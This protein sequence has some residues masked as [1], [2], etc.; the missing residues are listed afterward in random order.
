MSNSNSSNGS[1]GVGAKAASPKGLKLEL[2]LMQAGVDK[3]LTKAGMNVMGQM[4]TQAQ[5]DTELEADIARYAA[6]DAAR[7]TLKTAL[8]TLTAAVP[9]MRARYAVLKQ[10]VVAQFGAGNPQ[11]VDFGIKPKAARKPLTAEQKVLAKAKAAATRKA[12]G[13]VGPVAKLK[14]MGATPTVTIGPS[15]TTVTTAQQHRTGQQH[16]G[17]VAGGTGASAKPTPRSE[18]KAKRASGIA[19]SNPPPGGFLS[20]VN[21]EMKGAASRAAPLDTEP[22]RRR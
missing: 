10:A 7:A 14:T 5:L 12:R 15:G 11:L 21:A 18:G 19:G 9:N 13:T 2:T 20:G 1:A 3:D 17:E 6:V 16:A 4:V 22:L 8:A